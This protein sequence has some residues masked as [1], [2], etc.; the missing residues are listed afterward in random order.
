MACCLPVWPA[1]L[2]GPFLN[3]LPDVQDHVDFAVYNTCKR[4]LL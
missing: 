1:V 2:L 3:T 4:L